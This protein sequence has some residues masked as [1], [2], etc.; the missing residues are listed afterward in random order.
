MLLR[1]LKLHCICA[2]VLAASAAHANEPA[3]DDLGA[4]SLEQL[5]QMDVNLVYGASRYQ[6]RVTDAPASITIVTADDIR[7]FGYT[8]TAEALRNV[9]GMY[10]TNDRNYSYVGMRGFLRPGDYST[11][12]LLLVDGHR[13]NDNI[14]DSA[15]VGREMMIDI[16][17]IERIEV[18]RGPSSSIYGSSAFL[19]VI[20]VVTKHGAQINGAQIAAEGDTLDG[21]TARA[22]YGNTF[23]NGLDWFVSGSHYSSDGEERL[24]YPEFDERISADPR[25]RNHGVVTGMDDEDASKF[26]TSV[27]YNGFAASAYYSERIKQV[28]TAAFGTIFGDPD[29]RNFDSRGYFELAYTHTFNDALNLKGRAFYDYSEYWG[30]FPTDYAEEGAPPDRVIYRDETIGEWVGTE[31]QINATLAE[32]YTLAVGTEYRANTREKQIAMDLSDPIYFYL[33]KDSTSAVFGVF[34]Q[35]EANVR[36]NLS[37]TAGLRYD[38]YNDSFGGTLNPRLAMI[39]HPT[40]L[41]AV[42]AL[43]GDAFRAPNPYERYYYQE[44]QLTQEALEPETIRTYE[45]VYEQFLSSTHRLNLSAYAYDI[46]DLITQREVPDSDGDIYFANVEAVRARGVEAELEGKYDSGWLWRASFAVQ[47]SKDEST[48]LELSMSPHR[49]AKLSASAP[50]YAKQVYANL[51]LQYQSEAYTLIR[52]RSPDFVLANLSVNTRDLW[53]GV[54]LSVGVY[55]LLN[56][57]DAFAGA[58]EHAQAVLTQDG[59]TY[60]GKFTVRF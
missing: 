40:E 43:F 24:Y 37:F 5:M 22:T 19:G 2:A 3:T 47:R 8:T 41:S 27:R 32:R 39:Y 4:L 7:R 15:A 14:Y 59:R 29:F 50:I 18:I 52:T 45:L 56:A 6:Q 20:N 12:V 51:E 28:P 21:Y 13:L 34:A 36:D 26:F 16:D 57:R 58:E 53:N 31:W 23:D 49:L 48:G 9:R 46:E 55:N 25:A 42:K 1:N 60:R 17:W 35:V 10:V 44:T 54:E 11:R 38:D 33:D 30:T